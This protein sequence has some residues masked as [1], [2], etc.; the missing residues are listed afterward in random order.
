MNKTK[1]NLTLKLKAEREAFRKKMS[2]MT[3]LEVYD[4]WYTVHFFEAYY[5]FLVADFIDSHENVVAWLAFYDN[6]IAF[7]YHEWMG[8]D[9]H[10]SDSWDDMLEWLVE[11]FESYAIS[12]EAGDLLEGNSGS[13]VIKVPIDIFDDYSP[14]SYITIYFVDADAIAQYEMIG[15]D[16]EGITMKR[17]EGNDA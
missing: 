10:F 9:A 1:E 5:E 6:P 2:E 17:L 7:L 8:C 15:E 11:T 14:N 4:N 12:L 3:S 16:D 13:E